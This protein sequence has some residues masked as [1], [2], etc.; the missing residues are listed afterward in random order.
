MVES[1]SPV[2][3]LLRSRRSVRRFESRA[4]E[5]ELLDA[6]LE[7]ALR[8]PSSKMRRPWHFVLVTRFETLE[9]LSRSKTH[10]SSFLKG[11]PAAVVVLAEPAQSDVWVEDA[12]IATLL[13]Q[14]TAESL[15]LGSCWIQIRERSFDASKSSEEYVREQLAIPDGLRV[16]TI[17]ALGWPAENLKPHEYSSLPGDRIHRESFASIQ[18]PR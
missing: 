13:L 18:T 6:L 15:G 7:S 14:L 17:V 12:S 16:A 11:A 5:P 10:G 1:N 2:L 9:A 4:L 8:S 3:R